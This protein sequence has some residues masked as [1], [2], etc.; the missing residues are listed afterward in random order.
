[1]AIAKSRVKREKITSVFVTV[2]LWIV[3][4]WL[5]YPLVVLESLRTVSVKQYMY[6]CG[7]GILIMLILFG[8]NV[9][10]LFMP[11]GYSRK[12]S[13]LNTA[14]LMIYTVCIG[15][16]IVYMVSRLI[17]LYIRVLGSEIDM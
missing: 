13:S 3:T 10:D 12:S 2:G 4:A 1:M 6:R 8:R 7:L 17:V 11:H 15:G 5:L 16:T 9:F 14:L